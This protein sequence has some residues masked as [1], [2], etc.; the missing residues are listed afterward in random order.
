MKCFLAMPALF[1]LGALADSSSTWAYTWTFS[2]SSSTWT[3]ATYATDVAVANATATAVE[4]A[5]SSVS[6]PAPWS[7]W[8]YTTSYTAEYSSGSSTWE[9]P[10]AV[11][12]SEAQNFTSMIAAPTTAVSSTLEVLATTTTPPISPASTTAAAP[13]AFTGG[14]VSEKAMG[15]GALAVAGLAFVL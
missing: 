14:A 5:A 1:A 4:V 2:S 13:S 6:T 10:T 9:V 12:Y 3:S 15:L 11:S 8:L 7:E